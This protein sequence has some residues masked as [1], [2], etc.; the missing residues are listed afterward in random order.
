[1]RQTKKL[2]IDEIFDAM[3]AFKIDSDTLFDLYQ[4]DQVEYGEYRLY[5]LHYNFHYNV[6]FG[7]SEKPSLLNGLAKIRTN[8]WTFNYHLNGMK[9]AHAQLKDFL[10]SRDDKMRN[11]L[12]LP[13]IFTMQNGEDVFMKVLAESEM[14]Y[15]GYDVEA[16]NYYLD[17]SKIVSYRIMGENKNC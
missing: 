14:E 7:T 9:K 8:L 16:V 12:G 6:L 17:K 4:N 3:G 15:K 11:L 10:A 2:V 1:M 13:V 5:V